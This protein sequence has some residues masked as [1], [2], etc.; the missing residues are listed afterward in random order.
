MPKYTLLRRISCLALAGTILPAC[1]SMPPAAWAAA[2]R[3]D[4][5][6]AESTGHSFLAAW[7]AKETRTEHLCLATALK[8]ELGATYDAYILARPQL[9][10]E[11]GW[12]G[13]HAYR[14][15]LV[16]TE[17]V[18]QDQLLWW[19]TQQQVYLGMR[20]TQQYYFEFQEEGGRRRRPGSY[21]SKAPAQYLQLNGRDLELFL[22]DPAIRSAGQLEGIRSF[23]IA[24]EW[25]IRE[26]LPPPSIDP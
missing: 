25:K 5:A 13:R 21:L 12:V 15:E 18:G 7:S 3:P 4:F 11:I 8:E 1:Q 19:G 9:E 26:F 22:S 24:S 14:L 23:E 2:L 6:T 16:A 20:M 10:L 17:T